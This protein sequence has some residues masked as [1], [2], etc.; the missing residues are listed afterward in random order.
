MLLKVRSN[1]FHLISIPRL[2]E[3]HVTFTDEVLGSTGNLDAVYELLGTAHRDS[4]TT[5]DLAGTI[6]DKPHPER[7][8]C[9]ACD[10]RTICTHSAAK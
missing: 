9:T 7:G 6:Y 1:G 2:R 10:V 3:D 4:T 5:D 8:R